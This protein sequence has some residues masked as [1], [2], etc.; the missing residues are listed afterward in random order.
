VFY[1][2]H[3]VSSLEQ[4]LSGTSGVDFDQPDIRLTVSDLRKSQALEFL[5]QSGADTRKQLAIINPGATNSRAKCWLPERFAAVGDQLLRRGDVQVALIGSRAESGLAQQ[6][7]QM[8][9]HQPVVLTGQTDLGLLVAIISL[10]RLLITNDTGPAHIGA[11]V[12]VPTLVIFGPTEHYATRPFSPV[13][14]VVRQPVVCS[15]CMLRECPIDHRCM[16]Q[17]TTEE[18]MARATRILDSRAAAAIAV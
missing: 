17:I 8:M 7:T 15:P 13:A 9:R 5:H 11:A 18:V 14:E 16:T 1:Y 4:A 10:A 6:I 2:L 3:L 12:G